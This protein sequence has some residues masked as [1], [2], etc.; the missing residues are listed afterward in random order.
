MANQPET[1]TWEAGIYQLETTDPVEGGVGGVSNE[2]LRQLGNR[3]KFLKDELVRIEAYGYKFK[4]VVVY[5]GGT[6]SLAAVDIGKLIVLNST[7]SSSGGNKITLPPSANVED[8]T[9]IAVLFKDLLSF[10]IQPSG[11]DTIDGG[12]RVLRDKGD[13]AIFT[14]KGTAWYVTSE[15]IANRRVVAGTIITYAANSIPSGYL[16]ANGAAVSRT[17]YADLFAAIGTTFG[18]GDGSTTFNLPDLRGEFIRGFDDGRGVD[19]GRVF[20]SAQAEG[21]NT[22]GVQLREASATWAASGAGIGSSVAYFENSNIA[23]YGSNMTL[24]GDWET[25]PRNIA[26]LYLIKF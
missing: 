17:T 26:L 16:K 11:S 2:P 5:T 4:D 13:F 12:N 23:A 21:V 8:G 3:T 15:I 19:S 10:T 20:G 1:S 14:K 25:R 18:V 9:H 24:M 7:T 6:V 22:A